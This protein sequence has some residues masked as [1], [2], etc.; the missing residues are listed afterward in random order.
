MA[1]SSTVMSTFALLT[2][3]ESYLPSSAFGNTS[4]AVCQ[5]DI[6]IKIK[7]LLQIHFKLPAVDLYRRWFFFFP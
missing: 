7:S 1:T 4:T 5:T 6:R 2:Q 3:K